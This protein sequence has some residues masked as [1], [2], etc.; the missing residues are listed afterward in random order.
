MVKGHLHR[1]SH[2]PRLA[3]LHRELPLL[4]AVHA[5]AVQ[6]RESHHVV[7]QPVEEHLRGVALAPVRKRDL[8]RV[9]AAPEER[10]LQVVRRVPV[11]DGRSDLLP[12]TA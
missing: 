10:V 1:V 6:R 2:E 12:P 8:P 5:K 4:L 7:A 3:L 11:E 9:R